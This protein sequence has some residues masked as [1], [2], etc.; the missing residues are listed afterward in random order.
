MSQ[1]INTILLPVIWYLRYTTFDRVLIRG[2]QLDKEEER[3]CREQWVQI[4]RWWLIW[5]ERKVRSGQEIDPGAAVSVL[6]LDYIAGSCS[7]PLFNVLYTFVH[8]LYFATI[9]KEMIVEI[10]YR[11]VDNGWIM[12][13]PSLRLLRG[14][15]TGGVSRVNTSNR[16]LW[17]GSP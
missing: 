8:Q 12:Q 5:G 14:Q 2:A 3:K 10:L 1:K 15:Y 16:V 6:C 11:R 9:L 17:R 13:Q 4:S 7:L